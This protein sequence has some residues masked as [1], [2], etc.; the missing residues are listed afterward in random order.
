MVVVR[1][2]RERMVI[3]P[4]Q[5]PPSIGKWDTPPPRALPRQ[6]ATASSAATGLVSAGLLLGVF[7]FLRCIRTRGRCI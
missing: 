1:R 4:N 2:P 3:L 5:Q 7:E 6:W